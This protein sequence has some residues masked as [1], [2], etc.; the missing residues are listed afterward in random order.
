VEIRNRLA[1]RVL[2]Y[3]RA[4]G[5]QLAANLSLQAAEPVCIYVALRSLP[6]SAVAVSTT[7]KLHKDSS[8]LCLLARYR[9][10]LQRSRVVKH[11]AVWC[12]EQS[13]NNVRGC[14]GLTAQQRDGSLL[15]ADN[16]GFGVEH[17]V[18]DIVPS[19]C[20]YKHRKD[21]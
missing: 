17:G 1:C 20:S 11:L 12:A 3:K 2:I 15:L 9:A 4:W 16:V 19:S 5:G 14:Q 8:V 6:V 18:L 10:F 21:S 13:A 7:L